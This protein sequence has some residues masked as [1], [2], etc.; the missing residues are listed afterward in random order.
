MNNNIINNINSIS[1][2]NINIYNIC[3]VPSPGVYQKS[4]SM[5]SK[6]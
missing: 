3:T 2:I 5:Q 1:N 6:T 4:K